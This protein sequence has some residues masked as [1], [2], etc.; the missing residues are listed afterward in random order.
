M[1]IVKIIKQLTSNSIINKLFKDNKIVM[2]N[3]F[4]HLIKDFNAKF[5]ANNFVRRDNLII[6]I[7]DNQK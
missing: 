6:L 4:N 3:Q 5:K 1:K 2:S 7:K